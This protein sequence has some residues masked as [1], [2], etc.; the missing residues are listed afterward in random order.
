ML[1]AILPFSLTVPHA[2]RELCQQQVVDLIGSAFAEAEAR[3][4]AHVAESESRLKDAQDEK[5][6]AFTA[7]D[8]A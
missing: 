7:K 6:A 4:V 1:K 2:E 5:A 8:E 3:L